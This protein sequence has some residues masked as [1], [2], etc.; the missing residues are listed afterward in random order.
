[1]G[2]NVPGDTNYDGLIAKHAYTVLKVVRLSN[3]ARLV[4]V[5]N[6]LG[7]ERFRGAYSDMDKVWTPELLREA[8]HK[9]DMKDGV[10]FITHEDYY[11]AMDRTYV[12]LNNDNMVFDFFLRLSDSHERNKSE[13]AR[14]TNSDSP[15]TYFEG[16]EPDCGEECVRHVLTV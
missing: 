2:A 1:M 5:R 6:P 9:I 11:K 8:G 12:G 15:T 14:I 10:F 3:G 16:R 4:Q 7:F 13:I